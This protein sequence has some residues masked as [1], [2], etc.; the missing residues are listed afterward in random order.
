MINHC[1][2]KGAWSTPEDYGAGVALLVLI[3]R[4]VRVAYCD[5]VEEGSARLKRR[6]S[7]A[8]EAAYPSTRT[9]GRKRC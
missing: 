4:A 1:A 7:S 2:S 8:K 6:A 5:A 9:R 3:E